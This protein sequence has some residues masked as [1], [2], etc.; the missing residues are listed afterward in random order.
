MI[1]ARAA[2]LLHDEAGM[3]VLHRCDRVEHG[4]HALVGGGAVAAQVELDEERA[5]VLRADRRLD[6]LH[7]GAGAEHRGDVA[8]D[9]VRAC[10]ACRLHEHRL[11]G[12]VREAGVREDVLGAGS[13]AV[14]V[15]GVGQLL[16]ADDRAD[17]DSGDDERDPAEGGRLPVRGAPAAGASSE[18]RSCVGHRFSFRLGGALAPEDRHDLLWQKARARSR[19]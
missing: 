1:R 16:A 2:E 3:R 6:V 7:V 14:G 4:L 11:G 9:G 15:L 10:G 12:D 5:T 17:R 13:L 18:V 8:R 19:K